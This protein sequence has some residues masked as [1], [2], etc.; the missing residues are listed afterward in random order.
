MAAQL[1]YNEGSVYVNTLPNERLGQLAI[2]YRQAQT[3]VK[4]LVDHFEHN[5]LSA[6]E[7][8]RVEQLVQR[9]GVRVMM[10]TI[11]DAK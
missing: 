11:M 3:E 8:R 9:G 2:R 10:N 7:K 1:V 4:Q 6:E 5:K